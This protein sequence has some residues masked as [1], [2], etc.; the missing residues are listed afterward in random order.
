MDFKK[1]LKQTII[2]SL[3]IAIGQ[4]G[5]VMLGVVDSLMVGKIGSASLAAASLVNSLFFLV[6]VFGI[7]VSYAL[8][9]LIAIAVGAKTNNE[10]GSLIN[11]SLIV[12]LVTAVVIVAVLWG[13]S[14]LIPYM[15][16]PE[17]VVG[18]AISYLRIITLSVVPFLIFQTY[19]QFLEGLSIPNP[20][21]YIAIGANFFNAFINWI[22]IFGKFGI[23]P[24]GLDG[25]GYATTI[26]RTLMA[27]SLMFFVF[28]YQRVAKYSPGLNFRL[29]DLKIIKKIISIG[30]PTGFQYLFEV[31]A[32]SFSAIMIGW[33]GKIPLAAHQVAISLASLTYMVTLGI[34]S[35]GTI[36]VGNFLG[37]GKIDDVKKAG[38]S[39]LALSIS[40]MSVFAVIFILFRNYL[41]LIFI[42]EKE[43]IL[44]AANLFI[45]A[46][47]FQL[48]DGTQATGLG[49]LR[50]LTDVKVPLYLSF[51]AY[52]LFGIPAGL[53]FGFYLDMGT[54]GIW[55]GL[56]IGLTILALLL[57]IRFKTKTD[58]L[59]FSKNLGSIS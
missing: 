10:G 59:L 54:V 11:N 32:F 43:V 14:F 42:N 20:P 28:K 49:I 38:Y 27:L 9:P 1:H 24:M 19:R 13:V 6:L 47:F 44:L 12:N 41:P 37:E 51:A 5:H 16:Q 31:A 45:I 34:S 29:F 21:M 57:V 26:T 2:L 3:P 39:A 18:L 23:E 25:A 22:F 17:D 15:S 40:L 33:L 36:R 52:W 55:I 58:Q 56:S 46:G 50:G 53:F 35:A 4:L 30:I 48:S 7:G 8:T